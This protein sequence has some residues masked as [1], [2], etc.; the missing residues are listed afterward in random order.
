ML[1][2]LAYTFF[3]WLTGIERLL[4]LLV[5]SKNAVWSFSKGGKEYGQ[6]HYP[7]MV[8]L[9]TGLLLG[10]LLEVWLL[11]RSFHWFS[12]SVFLLLAIAAQV[13][14][15]WCILTLGNQ[16]NTRVIIV[17]GL[18]RV[19]AGPY[20]YFSHPNYVAVIL[21]GIALPM[22]HNC[23]LTAIV[24]NISNAILL[25]VRLQTENAAL[26]ELAQTNGEVSE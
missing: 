16:W 1:S 25:M 14:R 12:G 9:H 23:W 15:W 3:L 6:G 19:D 22:I 2:A 17:P 21:E 4:E 26:L 20:Q 18:S 11:D 8:V 13:L 24:F 5:A 7:T 10:C